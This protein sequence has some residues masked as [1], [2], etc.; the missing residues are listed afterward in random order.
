MKKIK[1]GLAAVA[2]SFTSLFAI[3]T[4][5][6]IQL[7]QAGVQTNTIINML[8]IDGPKKTSVDDILKLRKENIPDSILEALTAQGSLEGLKPVKID[9]PTLKIEDKISIAEYQALQAQANASTRK[10]SIDDPSYRGLGEAGILFYLV[11]QNPD[12]ISDDLIFAFVNFDS[13]YSSD[14]YRRIKNDEF[15]FNR[16]KKGIISRMISEANK[17]SVDHISYK[18][19]IDIGDYDFNQGCFTPDFF[20]VLDRGYVQVAGVRYP[21][22]VENKDAWF[23]TLPL[24]ERDAKQ[25]LN[26]SP[27]RRVDGVWGFTIKEVSK[28]NG[29]VVHA[30]SL[31]LLRDLNSSGD[32]FWKYNSKYLGKGKPKA[33]SEF[34]YTGISNLG[35]FTNPEQKK[36]N[37]RV[38]VI[39]DDKE[40]TIRSFHDR[41]SE[42]EASFY[43]SLPSEQ[44]KIF[45]ARRGVARYYHM[46]YRNGQARYIP[47]SNKNWVYLYKPSKANA[48]GFKFE[49]GKLNIA[50][51]EIKKGFFRSSVKTR[52]VY[53]D[54]SQRNL[55]ENGTVKDF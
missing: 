21:V 27:N 36:S 26:I 39:G 28:E 47:Y 19:K 38:F 43:R 37:V 24:G 22:V 4:D 42:D 51:V 31:N 18:A 34:P 35:D 49:E 48:A 32:S 30:N 55:F 7:H 52:M 14:F 17:K 45:H 41:Y 44:N 53:L 6:I 12:N 9:G 3:T 25:R 23:K 40:I 2:C 1:L 13:R 5:E 20:N 8:R 16:S 46:P 33:H 10:I 11:K 50:I 54:E 15:E 29:V